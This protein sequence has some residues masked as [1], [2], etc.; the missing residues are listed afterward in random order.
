MGGVSCKRLSEFACTSASIQLLTCFY[1][2][3]IFCSRLLGR[4]TSSSGH[5]RDAGNPFPW[6]YWNP[7][8]KDFTVYNL[9]P[10]ETA[11]CKFLLSLPADGL[12]EV[13]MKQ[14]RLD[15]FRAQ[16]ADT[17]KMGPR[18]ILPVANPIC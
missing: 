5:I 7:E 11:V 12:L 16:L 9:D 1:I 14:N 3:M 8:V 15:K 6:V 13:K 10:L 17:S 18:S 2:F 4:A